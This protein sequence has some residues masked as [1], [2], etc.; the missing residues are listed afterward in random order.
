MASTPQVES[1]DSDKAL[2]R[3]FVGQDDGEAFSMLMGRHADMVYTTSWRILGDAALAADA[4]QETFFQLVK[5]ADKI[6]GSISGWLHRVATRRAVDLVRQN[7]SRRNREN[8][9]ALET[10]TRSNIWSEV[11]PTVD[12]AL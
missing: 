2:L 4:V 5:N 7:V 10:D 6:T 9:Y 3:R 11:E 12:E 8:R 1:M